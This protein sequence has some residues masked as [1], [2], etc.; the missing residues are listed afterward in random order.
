MTSHPVCIDALPIEVLALVF[1]YADTPQLYG[2]LLLVCHK[3]NELAKQPAVWKDSALYY[4]TSTLG[5]KDGED[6]VATMFGI[7]KSNRSRVVW[8]PN[9][10]RTPPMDISAHTNNLK[11]V[12][13]GN[14]R[15]GKTGTLMT[16]VNGRY[17]F[18]DPALSGTVFDTFSCDKKV[19]NVALSLGLW[20]T[21]GTGVYDRLRAL[22]YPETD[23]FV[24]LYRG[25]K[26]DTFDA[27]KTK[28]YPDIKDLKT[29]I[30]LAENHA[31]PG[32]ISN[33][34][35]VPSSEGLKMAEEMGAAAFVQYCAITNSGVEQ[36]FETVVRATLGV[37][38]SSPS[39]PKSRKG[40]RTKK[41][42]ERCVVA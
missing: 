7:L 17:P 30:V 4:R 15:V 37:G 16:F 40:K 39:T 11:I 2:N 14:M 24:V 31:Y 23:V 10:Q 28:W 3:W 34:R 19:E 32:Y 12:V 22:S 41:D 27:V 38:P 25:D 42:K 21:A 9:N 35:Q 26:P 8:F 5:I 36:L 18:D 6:P 1:G 29:V 20:D 33:E 13:L